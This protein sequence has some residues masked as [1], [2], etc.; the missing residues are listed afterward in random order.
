MKNNLK[1]FYVKVY[2]RRKTEIFKRFDENDRL[3]CKF[4]NEGFFKDELVNDGYCVTK[5]SVGYWSDGNKLHFWRADMA[6]SK[7]LNKMNNNDWN[8]FQKELS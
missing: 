1:H 6:S 7:I 4:P 3:I 2:N 8:D 5:Q